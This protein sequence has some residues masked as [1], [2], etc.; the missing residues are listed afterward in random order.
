METIFH[1]FQEINLLYT[2]NPLRGTLS[3]SEDPDENAAYYD[4]AFLQGLHCLL[5]LKQPTGTEIQHKLEDSTCGLFKV[6]N[7]QS[8]KY[9]IN[10]NGKSYQNTKG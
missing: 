3:N 6:H 8:H 5:R 1:L 9:C 2:G 7:G 4:A 10:I